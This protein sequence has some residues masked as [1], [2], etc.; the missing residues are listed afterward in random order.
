MKVF[1][2]ISDNGYNKVKFATA[3]KRRCLFNFLEN[4]IPDEVTVLMDK[5][6]PETKEFLLNY[7]DVAGLDVQEIEGGSSAQSFRIAYEKALQLPDNEIVYLVEDD[8]WHLPFSR[9]CLL[10]G[11]ERA[12]YA[13]LYDAPDKYVAGIRGGNPLIPEDGADP[14]K[15]FLT[16]STHWRLT[17][18][19][20][21]TFASTVEQLREDYEVWKKWCFP[22][23]ETTHPHD[24][25]C[26]LELRSLGRA[27]VSPIPTLSTHCEPAWSA[28]LI[29]WEEEMK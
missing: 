28:P 10:E 7:R 2:R 12:H 3:T 15:V 25:Q 8:Y 6:V 11:I 18:S 16:K 1:Y 23:P 20:T 17:N 14:T 21:C 5:V 24:F 13:T 27:L 4:W 26:F 29:D 22:T 19:T 9:T